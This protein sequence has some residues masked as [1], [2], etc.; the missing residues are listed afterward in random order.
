M[1][2]L[3]FF[4]I[5]GCHSG[6]VKPITVI[7][8]D[9]KGK[10]GADI[11]YYR[12]TSNPNAPEVRIKEEN[13]LREYTLFYKDL[14]KILRGRYADFMENNNYHRIRKEICE[15]PIYKITRYLNP[16]NKNPKS[17]HRDFY[18]PDI[19]EQFDKHYTIK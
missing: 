5:L 18:H 13:L 16:K 11:P 4:S 19:I 14:T 7:P 10:F 12:I 3:L 1:C 9:K 8:L 17:T 15:N 6:F 2:R